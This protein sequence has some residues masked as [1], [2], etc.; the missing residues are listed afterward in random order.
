MI[1]VLI[2]P[3]NT[4]PLEMVKVPPLHLVH[5]QRAV[6]GALAAIA[7]DRLFD[8]GDGQLIGV[9]DHRHDQAVRGGDRD[10]DVGV[11]VIDDLIAVD[12]ALTLGTSFS[13]RHAALARRSS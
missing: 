4:P 3:P 2:R 11:I 6:L 7:S 10:R 13:A 9:A 5:G 1:G 8:I 12:L